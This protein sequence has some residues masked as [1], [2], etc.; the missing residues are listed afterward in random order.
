MGAESEK[1]DGEIRGV[2]GGVAVG[3]HEFVELAGGV[4]G[5]TDES[6]GSIALAR[7]GKAAAKEQKAQGGGA[8]NGER[9][10]LRIP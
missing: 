7:G 10:H 8:V 9:V 5:S 1:H 4:G 2:F 3:A 6:V